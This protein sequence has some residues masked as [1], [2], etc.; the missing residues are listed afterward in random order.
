[1]ACN[2]TTG[3]CSNPPRANGAPCNDGNPCSLTDTCQ[4]G[5]CVGTRPAACRAS[6]QCHTAG[7]C[8]NATGA[9]SNPAKANGAPCNDGNACTRS[10]SCVAGAC[11]GTDPVVCTAA[12]QCHTAG[13]CNPTTGA[14]SNPAKANGA[15]CSDGN[16]CTL[17]DTCQA[18]ACVGTNPVVCTA[19]D[20]CHT[21]GTCDR[22]TG[23]CSN[24]AKADGAPCNDGSACTRT[25]TCAAGACVGTN[26][27]VCTASDQ[28]HTAGTCNPATGTCSNPARPDAAPCDNGSASTRTEAK[29][30][31]PCV[32]TNPVVCTASD[33]CH[34]AGTC[35]PATGACSNPAKADGTPCDDRNA[36]T[37]TDV[38]ALGTCVGTDPVVCTASDQCHAAGTCDPA[39][40]TCSNPARPDAAPCDDGNACTQTDTCQSASCVGSEPVV[41]TALN[42]C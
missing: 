3:A 34:T 21:A 37:E 33:Q 42:Q 19:S 13:T 36:C 24:P 2:P 11:V 38:C 27:V 16:A 41:C 39:T 4:A 18:G 28:C 25:D 31:V 8:S 35:N 30:S 7:T 20:Q 5:A 29:P 14:C 17:T 23:A 40:G 12:D 9:C 6:D 15:L 10:D 26:P 1:G 22:T 32:G